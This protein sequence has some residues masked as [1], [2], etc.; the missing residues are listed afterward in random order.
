MPRRKKLRMTLGKQSIKKSGSSIFNSGSGS[1]P[2]SFEL[3][4]T[5]AGARTLD[6]TEQTITDHR[7]TGETVN[8]GDVVKYINIQM[9]GLPRVDSV[10]SIGILEWAVVLQ[11]E[12]DPEVPITNV[13]TMTLMNICMNMYRGDCIYTGCFPI[14]STQANCQA[15][16][17]KIP[18]NHA[19]ITLGDQWFLYTYFRTANSTETSTTSIRNVHSFSYKAYQ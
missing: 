3:L 5:E 12:I 13:G 19:K 7:T 17:L 9:E 8:V 16:K 15:V 4:V 11:K 2:N 1:I 14:G 10:D 18:K 6:G